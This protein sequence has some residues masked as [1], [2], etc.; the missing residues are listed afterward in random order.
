MHTRSQRP[1]HPCPSVLRCIRVSQLAQ[2]LFLSPRPVLRS[3]PARSGTRW[4]VTAEGG[5][6][7][8]ERNEER[9]NPTKPK[10]AQWATL[11][12][13]G[14]VSSGARP[15]SGATASKA[16]GVS[17]KIQR[18]GVGGACCARGRARS[19]K[20]VLHRM[21]ERESLKLRLSR[22]SLIPDC[23]FFALSRLGLLRHSGS[24]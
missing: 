20:R 6:R 11:S 10:R 3:S 7:S 19:A 18:V 24:L 15:S 1:F 9:S 4:C 2:I 16:R 21:E 5:R 22:A 14:N 8:G 17:V 23:I 12:S 13:I